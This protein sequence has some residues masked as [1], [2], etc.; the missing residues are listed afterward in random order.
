MG[1][2]LLWPFDVGTFAVLCDIILSSA[3]CRDVAGT[4]CQIGEGNSK[5]SFVINLSLT[6]PF[7]DSWPIPYLLLQYCH[8]QLS[9]NAEW[10][11]TFKI[12]YML[13]LYIFRNFIP[14]SLPLLLIESH[15]VS[16][17]TI[18]IFSPAIYTHCR[19]FCC[20]WKSSSQFSPTTT[21]AALMSGLVK[22]SFQ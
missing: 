19:P 6:Q 2:I 13:F 3:S 14:S 10:N 21:S 11:V 4:G 22:A 17:Y 15:S 20:M 8:W 9:W 5:H 12:I 7:S 1:R 18:S 16:R